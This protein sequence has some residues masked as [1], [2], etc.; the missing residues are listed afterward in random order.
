MQKITC[1]LTFP[2]MPQHDPVLCFHMFWLENV[3]RS[4]PNWWGLSVSRFTRLHGFP[5]H[6]CLQVRV[7]WLLCFFLNFSASIYQQFH[8]VTC[9]K[10]K[11]HA[12]S[13]FLDVTAHT[14]TVHLTPAVVMSHHYKGPLDCAKCS[15]THFSAVWGN[16]VP[17]N[18]NRLKIHPHSEWKMKIVVSTLVLIM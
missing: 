6:L 17:D 15:L 18:F 3:P 14:F 7:R 12:S 5:P 8:S 9:N 10:N 13:C 11:M 2:S 1:C 4:M 16:R